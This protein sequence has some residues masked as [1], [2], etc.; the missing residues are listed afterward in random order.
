MTKE[1]FIEVVEQWYLYGSEDS[2]TF[3]GRMYDELTQPHWISVEDELP[4]NK[5]GFSD[6]VLTYNL[7]TNQCVVAQFNYISNCWFGCDDTVTHWMALPLPPAKLSN[8][9]RKERR[10]AMTNRQQHIEAGALAV[11]CTTSPKEQSGQ[12]VTL[13]TRQLN[14]SSRSTKSGTPPRA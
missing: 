5:G 13:P 10:R 8:V 6:E 12:T 11:P 1:E 2:I 4:P 14:A 9:E 3:L 7:A